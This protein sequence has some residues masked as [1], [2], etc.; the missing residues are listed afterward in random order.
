MED[1]AL[2]NKGFKKWIYNNAKKF[3]RFCLGKMNC[4]ELDII[5][6]KICAVPI[7]FS[8]KAGR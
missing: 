1:K 7:T 2:K 8:V 4:A 5:S 6:T 3:G